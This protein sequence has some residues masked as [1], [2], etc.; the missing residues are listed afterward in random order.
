M[1]HFVELTV[2]SSVSFGLV[3]S[4]LSPFESTDSM[5]KRSNF[6]HYFGQIFSP[7]RVGSFPERRH[8]NI[9]L[10][11]LGKMICTVG[12]EGIL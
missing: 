3:Y 5:L 8:E 10:M 12:L 11:V 6:F 7:L 1:K 9:L 4:L 2:F